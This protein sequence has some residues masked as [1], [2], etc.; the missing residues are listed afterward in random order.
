MGSGSPL[1]DFIESL[2]KFLTQNNKTSIIDKF[3]D[4]WYKVTR[5]PSTK[6]HRSKFDVKQFF[7][8]D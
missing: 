1:L 8:K 6:T 5:K 3:G 2:Q 4:Q 7:P